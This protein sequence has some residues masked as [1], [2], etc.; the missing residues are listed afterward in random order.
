MVDLAQ[1][2][3]DILQNRFNKIRAEIDYY[4]TMNESSKP[5]LAKKIGIS[6]SSMYNKYNDP[7]SITYDELVKLFKIMKLDDKTRADLMK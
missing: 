7:S 2:E 4:I 3:R 1:R 5:K 6:T